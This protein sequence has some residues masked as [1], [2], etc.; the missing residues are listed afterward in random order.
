MSMATIRHFLF[1]IRA[2]VGIFAQ[3]YGL[4]RAVGIAWGVFWLRPDPNE[5][6]KE[7]TNVSE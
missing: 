1:S 5:L 2:G 7:A 4:R 6:P 3:G